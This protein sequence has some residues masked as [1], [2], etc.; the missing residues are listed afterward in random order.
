MGRLLQSEVCNLRFLGM[1]IFS[2]SSKTDARFGV[3][4]PINF[5]ATWVSNKLLIRNP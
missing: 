4:D 5:A 2:V 3:L 1:D